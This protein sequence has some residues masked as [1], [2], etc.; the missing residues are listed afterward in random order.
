M[1]YLFTC[2]TEKEFKLGLENTR[3]SIHTR[4]KGNGQVNND[5]WSFISK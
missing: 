2:I 4:G 3:V 5:S 1:V